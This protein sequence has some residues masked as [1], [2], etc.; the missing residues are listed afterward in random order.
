MLLHRITLNL[1]VYA[2]FIAAVVTKWYLAH[3]FISH[4]QTS[5]S[6]TPLPIRKKLVC[7]L[8]YSHN[9][10]S[11]RFIPS[12]VD[13]IHIKWVKEWEWNE[14]AMKKVQSESWKNLHIA[15][16][17]FRSSVVNFVSF[18]ALF[19]ISAVHL[20]TCFLWAIK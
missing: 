18:S 10:L 15:L 5:C 12:F 1:I 11:R 17:C 13:E 9:N 4:F 8:N 6:L 19:S 7:I 2:V 16:V 14:C 20:K 3:H